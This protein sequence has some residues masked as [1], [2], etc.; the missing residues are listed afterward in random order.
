MAYSQSLAQ[1]IRKILALKL[2][3]QIFEEELE[4]K[5]LF[6]GLAFM[7]RGKMVLTVSSRKDELVMVRIGKEMEKQVLPRTGAR[8]TL[9][10]GRP[11]HGY[12]DLDIEGQKELPYWIDLALSYNQELTK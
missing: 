3:P 12:I 9:M 10:R 4:E 1:Q 7:I 11:Y 5:K 8:T 6:G 2:P